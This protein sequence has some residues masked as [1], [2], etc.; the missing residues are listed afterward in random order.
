[1]DYTVETCILPI[2]IY[3]GEIFNIRNKAEEA[4]INRLLENIIKRILK[5]PIGT[6]TEALYVETGLI[7]PTVTILRNRINMH[8]RLKRTGNEWMQEV[9]KE[10]K[11]TGWIKKT[12]QLEET[13]EISNRDMQGTE[14]TTK[15]M[16][17]RKTKEYFKKKIDNTLEQENGKSKTKFLLNNKGPWQPGK[18]PK[19]MKTMTRNQASLIFKARTRMLDCKLNFK[20]KYGANLKCRSCDTQDESQNHILVECHGLHSDESTQVTIRDI[21]NEDPKELIKTVTKLQN[22]LDKLNLGVQAPNTNSTCEPPCPSGN[23]H[24]N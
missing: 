7:E 5:V 22:T 11:D 21:F 2:I 10:E 17:E 1:M 24:D 4:A 15:K 6:P 20:N 9:I 18:C 23:V 16:V 8:I 19:Y 14:Y 3:A 13:L 12:R